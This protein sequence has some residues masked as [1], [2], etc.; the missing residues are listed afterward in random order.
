MSK[1]DEP[2]MRE[3]HPDAHEV[4][5]VLPRL[6]P[7]VVPNDCWKRDCFGDAIVGSVAVDGVE[8]CAT[9]GAD[10]VHGCDGPSRRWQE[11]LVAEVLRM[12]AELREAKEWIKVHKEWA[13]VAERLLKSIATPPK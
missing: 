8:R 10:G 3:D 11:D 4:R 7:P 1:P 6:D 9:S 5:V 13:D 2:T 12:Q